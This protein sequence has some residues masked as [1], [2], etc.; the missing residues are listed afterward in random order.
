MVASRNKPLAKA[1]KRA[2]AGAEAR[3]ALPHLRDRAEPSREQVD[4]VLNRVSA[5]EDAGN[6]RF[7]GQTYGAGVAAGIQWV[8]GEVTDN[9]YPED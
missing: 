2:P 3:A 6:N 9:P 7:F 8:L 1:A 5:D 4:D